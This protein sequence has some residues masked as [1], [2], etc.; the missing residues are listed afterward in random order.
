M[1]M[2][3][4]GKKC[5]QEEMWAAVSLY[6]Y[7]RTHLHFGSRP[8]CR[9][10]LP[11]RNVARKRCGL[12]SL[13][14]D[15]RRLICIL[16]AG[17]NADG[18]SR[19]EM[20]PGKDVGCCLSLLISDDSSAFWERA[21]MQMEPPGTKCRPGKDVGCCL[22]LLISDD[23]SAFWERAKMQMESPG[24]KCRQEKMWAAVSLYWYQTTHLHFGSR[25]KCRWSLPGRNVARKRCGLLSLF[26][27]TRRLIRILGA[28]QNADG[29][30]R[31]EMSPRRDVGCC[32]SLL[33]P[34]DSSACWER[35]KMQMEPPGKKCRPGRDV[36]CC[37][38]LLIS[39]DSSAFWE[40]ANMQMESPGTKCRPRRDVG[41]C[42][43]LLISDDLSAFWE[44]A[45]MQMEPPGKKCRQEK[46]W[47]AISLY[48]YQTTHLHFGSGPKCRWTLSGRNVGQEKMWAAVSLYWYQTTHLH[49]GSGPKC[50]WS[51]SGRNV[52]RK[53]CGLLSLFIDIRRLI[54]ILGA[55]Q[56]ADG[57]DG[58][59]REEMSPG[60]DVGC[61]LS[62]LISDDSSAFWER[63]KMQ[64]ESLGT[65]CRQ[66]KMW[67]AVSLYWYQTTHLHFGSG[68]KCRW[69]LPGRNVARKR[70][71]LLSL[72]IDIRRLILHFGSRPKC[73][74]SLPGRNVAR[75]RCG[76]LSLFIDTRRLICILGAGQN[77]DGVSREEM[78]PGR[79]VGCCLSLLISDDSS[80]FWERAKMQMESPGK[81]CR[82]EKM[83]A[84]VSLYWYQTTHLHF[85]SGPKCRWSLPGRNVARKRCG[86][87]SLF[88]DIRRLILHFG[89]RP[90]CRWSLPGRN[91]ARKR[92]GLL[93]LFIDIRRL[94]CILGAG[95]NAD[96]VSREE[97]SPKDVGCCLSLLISDDSSAFWERAKMQME[98]PGKK[99]RPGK[100]VGC[101]LSLLISD[102]SSAFW[103]RAKMQMD[104][105]GTKCRQEKMWAAV[106][107]YWYQT[108]HLHFGSGPKCRW[109][110]PGR[111]VA[112]K[113]CGLLSLFI[114]IRR[115][116]CI[117][118]A[119]QNADGVSRDEMSAAVSLYW[120]QTTHLHF[121][122][123]PKCRW[124]KCRPGR[125]VGCCL[126]LLISDDSYAFWEQ[127]EMQMESPGTKCRPRRDVDCCLSLLIPEDS[128]AFWERAKYCRWSLPGRNVGQEEMWAAVSLYWYQR[129]HTHFGSRPK[130]RWSLPGRNVARKRCGLLS[131]F[132]DIR[133]LI[134]ILGAGQ[135]ADGVSREEMSPGKD[136]GCCL[137]LLIS[138]D[139]SAFW[140]RAKM[141][142]ESPGKKC[143]Q[144]K[145]WAAVSLY[146]YQTTHLH[147]GSGPKC[148]WSLPGRN[149]ARKRC[150]LL[151]L[152]I[153]T[154]G[155]ICILGAGQNA[156]GLSR[157]EMSPGKDVGCCLS[158]LISDDSSAFWERAKMSGTAVSLYWYQNDSAFWER[159]GKKCR[160][161]KMSAVSLYW[162]QTTHTHFGER[163]K[164]QMESSRD[165]M[166]GQQ[167]RCGLLSLFIDTRRLICILGQ[168]ADGAGRNVGQEKRC[169]LLSLFI[170]I[171]RLICILGAGQNA[172]GPS[173]DEMS[174]GKDVGC[175]LSLLISDDSSAFWERAKMQMES[176]GKKCRQE[177]MWAAVS[178]YWY[179]TTHLHFGL[180]SLS[181]W[182]TQ[183]TH[184]HFGSGP[185]C[186]WSLPGRNVGQ[187]KMWAAVSL[188]WYQTTHLHF[189]S[190]PKCR[191]SLPGRNVGQEKMWAAG[192]L[193]LF[194]DIR[195]LICILGAG[196]NADGVSREEMS[197]GMEMWA[198]VSLYWY[199]TTHL[200][201][202]SRPKCRWSLSGRNVGLSLF[203]DTRRLI[204]ILG[205]G[206]NAD[207]GNVGQEEMWAAVS[208]YWYQTTHTAFWEQ[209]EMQMGLPGRN[210]GQ[211]E[212]WM[213]SFRRLIRILGSGPKMSPGKKWSGKDV[214]CCLS[215][216]I[217]G[218]IHILGA[219]QKCRWSLPGRN[220]ARK[221]RRDVG[222]CLSL[223]ISDDS[224]AFWERAKMQ[225][226]S[227]SQE[228]MWA[229]VSLLGYQNVWL[230]RILER[231]K[232]QMESLGTKCRQEEMWAAVSLYWYQT[233]HLH[234]GSRPKCRWSLSGRNVAR[235]DV[236]CCLSLL[237]SDDSSA[238]WE[239]AKMQMESPGKKCRQE[240]MW[241]AVSLYW[242]QTTHLHFGSRP[243]CRWSLPG[244]NVARKRCGL[245]SLF[246][247]SRFPSCILWR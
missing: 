30:S 3:P 90:K 10:S 233:T 20:S 77:A 73:R 214:G 28:G 145:M 139:S 198:A 116:I 46:M 141:Q 242:Y 132:I 117:L 182:Y 222:C 164:M 82:Q 184:L 221:R 128:Y 186:R 93:S 174:P 157:E 234:F 41:C 100:D 240:K 107:L 201:F 158:L 55:G 172:D 34:D 108:T 42:L 19:E 72:F 62:L 232:M 219:G 64:M 95:Q 199:Q 235:K 175:C 230:I 140:E 56:N 210:V 91:V 148:R 17:Q 99:C 170:D 60:K 191:W 14:I 185:K 123:G 229:A 181:Y 92:C 226:E 79:D 202:G 22:S 183:T 218:L 130:C 45:K 239:R 35:A 53:R 29:V 178:L 151:S 31:D 177:K 131:L 129:T 81:K 225:M 33:I 75:K 247:D 126:S 115:L 97:M 118:G 76:L 94:I 7:Q 133:R 207:G 168:N 12:L 205:A 217:R 231:A 204:C 18:V 49:F 196:Q 243:K 209:A 152:F 67:A 103:E 212:M 47:A 245:L 2:E 37:L 187:E 44:Q 63:A 5:R 228:K 179:Q 9:W 195:R 85:G 112:R 13:F 153:D 169:G 38:S 150:G 50:R 149:V 215:L 110:L 96:G 171:R 51:L 102:D 101:C 119:G 1:Q 143:R 111:N 146:W 84:A 216:L 74:W 24:K 223:L 32:L 238:F 208:L 113:R 11:G 80:A 109:S 163:A 167:K 211:E 104:P 200:H 206:Q 244:R 87:L 192:L 246:I 86:L 23:S 137:S 57:A 160:Q 124:R 237:I 173:R 180:L 58:V 193:S 21:K 39:D 241:A 203:I 197:P 194:I 142:M 213:L 71:G 114:D 144:E 135:N 147:F 54:C 43:S 125:D 59:S 89:S 161:E 154:R 26:I 162:Y 165:E 127:A 65:K 105:L 189:G 16:G 83:W 69:S 78:S 88:I 220:V 36:G 236:G 121:G 190:G 70:C 15:I 138:D 106:S 61:C 6:W 159:D 52:A 134:C 25:P 40:Q 27:D 48:W 4:P 136:V 224:S 66:E 176:P 227:P 68:P 122:S 120:Y 156:D 188:Y 155:L 166:S 98:S 8:K